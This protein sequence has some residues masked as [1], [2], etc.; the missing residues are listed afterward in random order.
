MGK[1]LNLKS[2]LIHSEHFRYLTTMM[3]LV[4]G[5]VGTGIFAMGEGFKNSGM[6][7]GPTLLLMIGIMNLNCQHILA[8]STKIAILV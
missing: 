4:K 5:Y 1:T 8:S 3:H 6:I 7:M 2:V